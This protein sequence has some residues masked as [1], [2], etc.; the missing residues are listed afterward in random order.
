MRQTRSGRPPLVL[1]DGRMARRR[2]TGIATYIG[3]LRHSLD[4]HAADDLRIE[5]VNGPPGLPRK[6]RLTSIGNL[7]LDLLWLHVLL[8]LIA[9]RRGADLIHAP[10]TWGPWWSPCPTVVTVHDL[11]WERVPDAFPESFRR[12][13]RLFARRSVRTARRV[14][15]VSE[16]TAAD[17][18]ELYR[19]PDARIRVVSNGVER[20]R[21]PPV[22]R[23]AFI[24]SAGIMEPRKR[25]P[26]LAAAH[27]RYWEAAP[28]ENR[29]RLVIVGGDGGD[30][31]NVRAVAGPGCEIRGFVHRDE[32]V[33]LY[34]RAT[35]LVYPSRYEGFGIPV[36]EALAHGC[37][38]LCAHNSSLIEIGAEAALFV[39]EDDMTVDGLADAITRALADR[40]EL[41]RR[42]RLG[43]QQ[44]ERYSWTATATATRDVYRRA[45]GR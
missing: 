14:I 7:V 12:Y 15:A 35:L 29:C 9:L 34:R 4:I 28:P 21:R 41:E 31:A 10:V 44:V 5:W 40:D 22:E 11:A 26:L 27:A 24:L 13:A 1:V 23:E 8:P 36:A 38:V 43:R 3:E 42:G 32:L 17:L 45:L 39:A 6:G 20:D 25:I 37:P 16:A 2:P 30:E 19:V 33:D 18:R